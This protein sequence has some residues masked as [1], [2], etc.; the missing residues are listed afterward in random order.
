V[1]EDTLVVAANIL[2]KFENNAM[3]EYARETLTRS[4]IKSNQIRDTFEVENIA[5][6][7]CKISAMNHLKQLKEF[8]DKG[9]NITISTFHALSNLMKKEKYASAAS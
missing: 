4:T 9:T 7:L 3:R 2:I 1:D 8:V 6:M 5:I